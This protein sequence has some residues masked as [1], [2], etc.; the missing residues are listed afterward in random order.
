MKGLLNPSDGRNEILPQLVIAIGGVEA[1][2][3]RE[4]VERYMA[5]DAGIKVTVVGNQASRHLSNE[6]KRDDGKE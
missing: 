5:S 4:M 1:I 3:A 6:R 2:E